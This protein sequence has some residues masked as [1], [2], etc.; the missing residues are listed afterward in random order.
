MYTY[1]EAGIEAAMEGRVVGGW[2]RERKWRAAR[3]TVY[4]GGACRRA[5]VTESGGI[6]HAANQ[7]YIIHP[8]N[9]CSIPLSAL[10][11]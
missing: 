2:D 7:S 4:N 9:A 11:T 10:P 1:R 5:V 8:S 6:Y 3:R